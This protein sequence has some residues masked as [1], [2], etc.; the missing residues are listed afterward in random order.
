MCKYAVV[1]GDFGER[2][3]GGVVEVAGGRV[4]FADHH[5]CAVRAGVVMV[6]GEAQVR[7]T[8]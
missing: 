5:R 8:R 6:A 7:Q 1:G 4:R 3:E 2:A